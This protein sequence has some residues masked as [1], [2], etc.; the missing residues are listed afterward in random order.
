[1]RGN[2]KWVTNEQEIRENQILRQNAL[3]IKQQN[4][5]STDIQVPERVQ[6]RYALAPFGFKVANVID[7][8]VEPT[9]EKDII[10]TL[11]PQKQMVFEYDP[12]L[13]NKLELIFHGE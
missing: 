9:E 7:F 2:I 13:L 4:P 11:Y 12:L 3:L 5:Y 10:C 6:E 8:Y 1:M